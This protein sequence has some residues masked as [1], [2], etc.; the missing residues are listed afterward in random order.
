MKNYYDYQGNLYNIAYSDKMREEKSYFM[1]MNNE[2]NT[3]LEATDRHEAEE[4]I[5]KIAKDNGW[6]QEEY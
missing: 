3:E 1:T 4:E 5:A 2:F 6:G